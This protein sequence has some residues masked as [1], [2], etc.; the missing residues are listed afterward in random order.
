LE[1]GVFVRGRIGQQ[2]AGLRRR[3]QDDPPLVPRS[4][5]PESDKNKFAGEKPHLTGTHRQRLLGGLLNKGDL[6]A[7]LAS[8]T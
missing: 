2:E 3:H 6:M 7:M 4:P 1:N 8:L 5:L